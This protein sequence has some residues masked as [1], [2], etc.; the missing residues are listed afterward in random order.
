MLPWPAAGLRYRDY[1][2]RV[3]KSGKHLLNIINDILDVSKIE[4]GEFKVAPEPVDVAPLQNECVQRVQEIPAGAKLSITTYI[5]DGL[6]LLRADTQRLRQVMLNVLTNAVK[7]TPEGG[8]PK[9][10]L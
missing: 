4:A 2:A 1:A 5:P 9:L 7:F 3:H 10:W 8:C 6:P